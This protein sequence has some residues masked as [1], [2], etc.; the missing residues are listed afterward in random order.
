[1]PSKLTAAQRAT[2]AAV[3][4]TFLPELVRD[5]DTAA[6]FATGA[7]RTG[8]A[9]RVEHLIN[10]LGDP[11]DGAR[12]RTLLTVLG[13]RLAN[14]ALNGRM[15]SFATLEPREREEVLRR[16]A[17]SPIALRRAGFQALK[18]LTHVAHFCWPLDDGMHPA[19]RAVGYPGPLDPPL[20]GAKPLPVFPLPGDKTLDCDV[21]VVG[22][23]AGGG[24]V[25]GV[26]TAAG[27]DVIVLEKGP[28]PG[29]SD[30]TQI[31]GDMLSA[32]YLDHG[33]L[34][35]QSGSMPILAG[36]CVGGGTTINWTTSFALP[37]SVRAEWDALSGLTL[38]A[39]PRFGESL[40]RVGRRVNVG[41]EW[42]TP[43]MRDAILE[44]G[45]R[46]LGWH[47]DQQPRNVSDC[48]QGIECG[49]CGYGCRHGAKNSTAV[50]YL[51]DATDGGARLIPR[52]DVRRI[53][54]RAGEATGV[55]A[56]VERA[57]GT[58]CSL[59]VRARAVVVAC[60]AIYTPALLKRSGVANRN[61]GR[62]LRLH[63][64]SAVV[65]VFPE[66]VEP[67]S[68]A[69]QTRYSDQF[70]NLRHG[71]GVR[72]ETGPVHFALP[73]SGFGWES[74]VAFREDVARLAHT[75]LVG[76]LLRDRDA[77]RL[78][79]SREGRPRVSYEPSDHDIEHLRQGLRGAGEILAAAGATD[80]MSL[81]TPPVRARPGAAGWLDTLVEGMDARGYRHCRM[82]FISFHQMGSAAMGREPG[83]SVVGETGN[84]HGVRGLYVAD[85]STFPTSS[86]V[87]PM[88][89]IMAIADHVARAIDEGW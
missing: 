71:Y 51:R 43:G 58:M 77:G 45:C 22:S 30:M 42:N 20:D 4:E 44:R 85:A 89:T 29:A 5:D 52:C 8:A 32:L 74:A 9:Q 67:W 46:A 55:E 6:L 39:S 37:R 84:V 88:I 14:L 60:G 10:L 87:N 54:V 73:A 50:T 17:I 83:R 12:L 80:V 86:G 49:Y 3:C 48:R 75:S 2:L 41:T 38:F 18:R 82:S 56:T 1:M 66:R 13:S 25:A 11:R 53:L 79:V 69:L 15:V 76:V 61:I 21:V 19:W 68:G 26:L 27:R 63:P 62:G 24:V 78:A 64:A 47:V 35:T 33:L 16:W 7:V 23:G 57:D 59:T 28:N 31:E 65:G 40:E 36:S 81:H 34:M 72:F 70:A